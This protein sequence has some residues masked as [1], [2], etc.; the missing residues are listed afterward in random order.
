M[1][2]A[3]Q[4]AR[5]LLQIKAIKLEPEEPFTWAS[6][7]KSPIYCDNRLALSYPEIRTFIKERFAEKAGR[8]EPFDLVAGVATAGI[9]HGVL[10]ADRLEKPF[11]YVRSKPKAHGRQNQIEG[12]L[13]PG[14]RVLVIED[15]ISTGG[16][17]LKAVEALRDAG[18]EIAGVLAIFTYGFAQAEEAFAR[19]G[20]AWGTLTDYPTLLEEAV[21]AHYLDERWLATLES[22][23]KDPAR[24]MQS[25][26]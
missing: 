19:A 14:Q 18:A 9:P 4:L 10:L 1:N 3:R 7:W 23:R 6:G 8:F 24:W 17:V 11:V 5:Y 22:W 25:V 15:L 12:L 26:G 16:S 13:E 20:V 21:A 2:A